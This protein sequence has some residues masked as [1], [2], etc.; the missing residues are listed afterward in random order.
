[1]V[2]SGIAFVGDVV[3]DDPVN[4]SDVDGG[5]GRSTQSVK[6]VAYEWVPLVSSAAHGR[7][8]RANPARLRL[9]R[10]LATLRQRVVLTPSRLL[11]LASVPGVA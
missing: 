8:A 1:M 7:P 3:A 10:G 5:R 6:E 11:P 4:R 9:F 2:C